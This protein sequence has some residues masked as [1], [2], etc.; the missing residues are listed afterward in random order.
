MI[1]RLTTAP[2]G[3]RFTWDRSG[4]GPMGPM[5]PLGPGGPGGPDI[6]GGPLGPASPNT[7]NKRQVGVKLHK[8]LAR[9]LAC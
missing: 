4:V 9:Q 5:K 2:L 1:F 6:P 3:P 8:N 7:T